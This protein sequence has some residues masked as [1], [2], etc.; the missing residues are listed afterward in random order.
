MLSVCLGLLR[1]AWSEAFFENCWRK[2]VVCRFCASDAAA[3]ADWLVSLAAND[4][5]AT[6]GWSALAPAAIRSSVTGPVGEGAV[7]VPADFVSASAS[8]ASSAGRQAVALPYGKAGTVRARA[9]CSHTSARS[10]ASFA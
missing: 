5:P 1:K 10:A 8:L 2:L 9:P 7:V 3:G 6:N 4:L